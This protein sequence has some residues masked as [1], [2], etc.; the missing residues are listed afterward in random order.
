MHQKGR[1]TGEGW[2]QGKGKGHEG[3]SEGRKERVTTEM[4]R[5]REREGVGK[6]APTRATIISKSWR[7]WC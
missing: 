1:A 4:G 5:R 3:S 6:L 2:G 7:L